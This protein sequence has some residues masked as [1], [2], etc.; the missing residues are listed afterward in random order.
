MIYQ[1]LKCFR[2]LCLYEECFLNGCSSLPWIYCTLFVRIIRLWK[3]FYLIIVISLISLMCHC[4]RITF[5][6]R[7]RFSLRKIHILLQYF[8]GLMK[9]IMLLINVNIIF[10]NVL[11][12]FLILFSLHKFNYF[13]VIYI[14]KHFRMSLY[15][16][17]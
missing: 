8:H 10:L 12:Y 5:L 16:N 11:H 2:V 3:G 7:W 14:D 13:Y 15:L 1:S 17:V 9:V 4:L 6:W